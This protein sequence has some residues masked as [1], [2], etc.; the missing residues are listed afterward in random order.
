MAAR[1]SSR[2]SL[3]IFKA[4]GN[5]FA[6]SGSGFG[7]NCKGNRMAIWIGKSMFGLH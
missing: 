4:N 2:L 7:Q 5:F 3:A 1:I 6:N